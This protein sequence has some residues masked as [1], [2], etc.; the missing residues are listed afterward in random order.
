MNLNEKIE[1]AKQLEKLKVDV[2]EAGFA[3]ASPGDFESVKTIAGMIKDSTVCSLARAVKKDIDAAYGAV[4]GAQSPRIHVFLA[5]SPVHM[6]YKLKMSPEEVLHTS[7]EMV[8]YARSLCPNVEFSAE[9]ASR[10]DPAFLVQVFEGVIKAGA[11]VINIPDTVGYSTPDEMFK[12]VDYI[13]K[14]TAG[15]EKCE[16]STHC[17]NDLGMGVANSL[18][19][20][21]A[22]AT[23]LECTINGLGERAG[24][25]ALEE[26]V[27]ALHTRKQYFDAQ[28]RINTTQLYAASRLLQNITGIQAPPNKAIVGANAFAHES[29]I[30]QHGVLSERT[31]Y[32]I[33]T[34]ES[35]GIPKNLMVLG[36]HSGRHAFADRLSALGYNLTEQELDKA[37]VQFK[38][39]TDK[40]KEILDRDIEAIVTNR[41]L[42]VQELYSLSR[43]II[44]SGNTIPATAMIALNYGGEEIENVS[45]GDGP[46]DAAFKAINNIA[47]KDFVLDNYSLRSVTEGQDALGE[48]VVKISFEGIGVTGRGLSTDVVESSIKAYLNGVNKILAKYDARG[49]MQDEDALGGV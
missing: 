18:A 12:L 31:T 15:I 8:A 48:A 2:I 20:V 5:T 25:A 47:K 46:V 28:C 49:G 17:H 10:S 45:M 1:V 37:F 13:V 9:D 4:K 19:A 43:F 21:S 33:M 30:H 40:K 7:R 41:V 27:M 39:L 29:G 6:Q 38:E 23:Q 36:K 32:E 11:S 44:N 22:G 16:I 14:H 26:L 34:P 35:V 24:N 3:I 42:E